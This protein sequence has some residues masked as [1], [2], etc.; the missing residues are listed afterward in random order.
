MALQFNTLCHL[1]YTYSN[2]L[3]RQTLQ[4]ERRDTRV[5]LNYQRRT[6]CAVDSEAMFP[7]R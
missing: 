7:G 5:D 1:S 4:L 2:N 3:R 6:F